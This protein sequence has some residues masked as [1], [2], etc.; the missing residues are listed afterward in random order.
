MTPLFQKLQLLEH[1]IAASDVPEF[2]TEIERRKCASKAG[3]SAFTSISYRFYDPH[4]HPV[5]CGEKKAGFRVWFC[6]QIVRPLASL[7]NCAVSCVGSLRRWPSQY[8]PH[9]DRG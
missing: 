5:D 6:R 2:V 4:L 7:R 8:N 3:S 1:S 9:D